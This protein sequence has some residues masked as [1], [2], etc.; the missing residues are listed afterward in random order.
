ME[1]NGKNIP[2]KSLEEAQKKVSPEQYR[3]F[4]E[5]LELEEIFVSKISS[6]LFLNK[7]YSSKDSVNIEIK[8][9]SYFENIEKYTFGSNVYDIKIKSG[10]KILLKSKIEITAQFSYKEIP[11]DENYFKIFDDLSLQMML[12][13][14]ARLNINR[15][16][17]DAGL[18]Y[19]TLPMKKS[20]F[21][22]NK[23][24]K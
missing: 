3:H 14:Y 4:L 1:K 6:E 21:T 5:Q 23:N 19:L 22:K 20:F 13:P 18:G 8:I 16:L 24:Q 12:F 15:I 17:A 7:K 2:S 10:N 11:F 9:K